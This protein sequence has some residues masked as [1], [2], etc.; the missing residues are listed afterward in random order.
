MTGEDNAMRVG[1]AGVVGFVGRV[2]KDSRSLVINAGMI[3]CS[4]RLRGARTFGW[5]RSSVNSAPRFC[6]GNPVPSATIPE[7]KLAKLL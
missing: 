7:P 3:V 5:R 2:E 6:S 4:G 1:F